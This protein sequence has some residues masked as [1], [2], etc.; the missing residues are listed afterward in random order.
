MTTRAVRNMPGYTSETLARHR[1]PSP[2]GTGWVDWIELDR[3]TTP[4]GGILLIGFKDRYWLD[5]TGTWHATC[6]EAIHAGE[7]ALGLNPEGTLSTT[8]TPVSR[9]LR[10][11]L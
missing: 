3:I 5:P 10:Q 1:D 9:V 11:S 8:G 7:A 6:R 4:S 2:T